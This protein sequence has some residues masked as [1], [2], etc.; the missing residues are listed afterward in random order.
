M[1][2]NYMNFEYLA[3]KTKNRRLGARNVLE[4]SQSHMAEY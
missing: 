4:L 1:F 2:K 3:L